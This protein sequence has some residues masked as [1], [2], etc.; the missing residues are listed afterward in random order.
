[1]PSCTHRI[2]VRWLRDGTTV[3]AK[4]AEYPYEGQ[5]GHT[6]MYLR[7]VLRQFFGMPKIL[8]PLTKL[9]PEPEK[10]WHQIDTR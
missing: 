10:H 9:L 2:I 1:M 3:S 8:P 6:N 5:N 7:K 4:A